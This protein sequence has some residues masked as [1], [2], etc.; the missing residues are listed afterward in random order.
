MNRFS[1]CKIPK[2]ITW[3]VIF[4]CWMPVSSFAQDNSLATQSG[5]ELGFSLSS[6]RY[7]EPGVM[8]IKSNKKTGIEYTGTHAFDSGWPNQHKGMFVRTELR[9]ATGNADYDSVSTGT[10][11]NVP[12]WNYEI[13]ILGGKDFALEGYTV[14]PY[15]GFGY[16]Y[17]FSDL[18]GTTTTNARG[19]RRESNYYS[20]PIGLTH[21]LNLSNQKQLYTTFE[22]DYL[23]RG[24]QK[25]M[26]SDATPAFSD[27][28]NPQ[29]RGYGL[30]LSTML[31]MDKW[32]VGP[33]LVYWQIN[34][35]DTVT[36]NSLNY[37]EPKNNTT[38]IGLKANY[39]F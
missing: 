24:L 37:T 25:T 35:S 32:T 27:V 5:H 30:R 3:G 29:R 21:K 18:R 33:S 36:K 14:S 20:I 11:S 38:E 31:R 16:R 26:I 19:Y 9:Y 2:R 6:Y 7:S 22:Y 34:A 10:L 8:N 23:V 15:I 12:D 1:L 13:R 17:L 28:S 4:S 39:L